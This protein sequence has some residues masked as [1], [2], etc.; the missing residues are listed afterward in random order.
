MSLHPDRSIIQDFEKT[1]KSLRR[2]A[3]PFIVILGASLLDEALKTFI[4][5]RMVALSNS[6]ETRIF[7]GYGPLSNFSAKID[8][9]LALDVVSR[10][11]Y[12]DL[13]LVNK[14]RVAFAHTAEIKDLH[15]E[16]VFKLL[17]R[18][19]GPINHD[20]DL[21]EKFLSALDVIIQETL[22]HLTKGNAPLPPTSS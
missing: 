17:A 14:I 12:D 2:F 3:Q 16:A 19:V 22:E 11:T 18:L 10:K 1:I 20:D 15:S 8:I 6:M 13:R 9:S 7:S 4:Q 5:L 21:S